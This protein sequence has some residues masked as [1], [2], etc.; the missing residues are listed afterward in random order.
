MDLE[1]NEQF[2]YFKSLDNL[3]NNIFYFIIFR[4]D[5]QRRYDELQ[6]DSVHNNVSSTLSAPAHLYPRV[7][8]DPSSGPIRDVYD[9]QLPR[10]S[11]SPSRS[12][13]ETNESR[14]NSRP[15]S[16]NTHTCWDRSSRSHNRSINN[17]SETIVP[18]NEN[19]T[20]TNVN[21]S[22]VSNNNVNTGTTA[23]SVPSDHW[24][25]HVRN[26]YEQNHNI[27]PFSNE[28][29][30]ESANQ[31]RIPQS[32]PD[33]NSNRSHGTNRNNNN[34]R[35]NNTNRNN[36][37]I[38]HSNISR[39]NILTNPNRNNTSS[40]NTRLSNDNRRTTREARSSTPRRSSGME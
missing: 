26:S 10:V 24:T 6:S 14:S 23:T 33:V 39:N 8:E 15:Q 2:L 40:E 37:V 11:L 18:S 38:S 3:S 7:G 29:Y 1:Y 12:A 27:R 17:S 31:S 30:V 9:I 35:T 25:R 5:C 32:R 20:T 34:N 16:A 36:R 4:S 21:S 28:G 13:P 22:S 19:S